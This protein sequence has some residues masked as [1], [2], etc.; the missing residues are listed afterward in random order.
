MFNALRPLIGSI[1]HVYLDDIII[2]SNDLETH[3]ANIKKVLLALREY[4]LY[5]SLKKTTL[6]A[7]ELDFL[8]HHISQ[9]GIEA[10]PKKVERILNWPI[11]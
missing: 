3:K 9:R 1:C 5:A 4:H 10:D 8:G 7:V 11:L 2:W 6:F